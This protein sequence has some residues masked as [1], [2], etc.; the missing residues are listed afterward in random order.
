SINYIKSI[1]KDGEGV[2][3][4]SAFV[5]NEVTMKSFRSDQSILSGS[6]NDYL[7]GPNG[8]NWYASLGGTFDNASESRNVAYGGA[9]AYNYKLRYVV[10]FQYRVDATSTNGPNIGSKQS[11]TISARWN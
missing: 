9:V 1:E 11:P 2:H 5:F 10:D 4:F 6:A 7:T 8:Y 3:N